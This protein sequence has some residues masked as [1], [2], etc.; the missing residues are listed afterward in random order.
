MNCNLQDCS[1]RDV[2]MYI[3]WKIII[4]LRFV[5]RNIEKP[6]KTYNRLTKR[7]IANLLQNWTQPKIKPFLS[8]RSE[9]YLQKFATIVWVFKSHLAIWAWIRFSLFFISYNII[10]KKPEICMEVNFLGGGGVISQKA[11]NK[12]SKHWK[13]QC[14]FFK[15]DMFM[16]G[17]L[18]GTSFRVK[19][20]E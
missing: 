7:L 11:C 8:N 20:L 1:K 14:F 16:A 9:K 15:I 17:L 13:D 12:G 10:K 4:M 5:S 3:S 19:G 6:D 18:Q 2:Y